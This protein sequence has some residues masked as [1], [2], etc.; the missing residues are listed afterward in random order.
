MKLVIDI[1]V[2]VYEFLLQKQYFPD[3]FD[4]TKRVIH[5]I[6]LPQCKNCKYFETDAFAT[7]DGIPLI[8][9]HEVCTKWGAG[10][11]T[12]EDGYCFMFEQKE[13]DK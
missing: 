8:V 2:E 10:C 9:G 7:I 13:V 6:P 5:G 1:P 4:V 12:K 11:K 3:G